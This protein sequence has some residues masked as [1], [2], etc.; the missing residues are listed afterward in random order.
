MVVDRKLKSFDSGLIRQL[1]DGLEY[2]PNP[3]AECPVSIA[4]VRGATS[5]FRSG[6]GGARLACRADVFLSLLDLGMREGV[7]EYL[8]ALR[9]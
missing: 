1:D 2:E 9:P 3:L 5:A 8:R 4:V 6:A 7:I